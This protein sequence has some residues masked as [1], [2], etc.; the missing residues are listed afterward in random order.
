MVKLNVLTE[1]NDNLKDENNNHLFRISIILIK[2]KKILYNFY[3]RNIAVRGRRLV[4]KQVMDI[5]E[6]YIHRKLPYIFQTMCS[7]I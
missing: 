6:M 4:P 3:S 7:N 1:K 5:E 2:R